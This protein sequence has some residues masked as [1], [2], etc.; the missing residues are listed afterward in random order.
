M[1]HAAKTQGRGKNSEYQPAVVERAPQFLGSPSIFCEATD[2]EGQGRN[3]DEKQGK[4][5]QH[6]LLPFS[7][8][9][10][11]KNGIVQPYFHRNS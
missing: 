10:D 6:I 2:D 4:T 11:D 1:R 8:P 3:Q 5:P 9:Y 7:S